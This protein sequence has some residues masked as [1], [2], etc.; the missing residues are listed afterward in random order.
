MERQNGQL[1]DTGSELLRFLHVRSTVW[2]RSAMRAPWGFAVKA[3]PLAAFHLV[4]SGTC[5]LRV[6]DVAETLV[7]RAGDLVIVPNGRAH[8]A[9]SDAGAK[10]LLLDDILAAHPPRDGRLEYG[11]TGVLTDLVCGGFEVADIAAQPLLDMLPPVLRIEGVDGAPGPEVRDALRL[12]LHELETSDVAAEAI[13]TRLTDVLL[14]LA[15]R[16]ALRTGV[17]TPAVWRDSAIAAAIAAIGQHPDRPWTLA[18]LASAANL[19]RS[20]LAE[21]FRA[22]TGESPIRFVARAR[23]ARA[24]QLLR[25]SA[26]SVSEIA[27]TSGFASEASFSR[28]FRRRFGTAPR[29]YRNAFVTAPRDT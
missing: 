8:V 22:A 29:S 26:A 23:L 21:R 18:E 27:E 25:D 2:C 10:V 24:S 17:P 15:I 28:A 9:R 7:L 1:G 12:V 14:A 4:V 5:E 11:G 20:A 13:L 19:S 16:H 3:R 6:D